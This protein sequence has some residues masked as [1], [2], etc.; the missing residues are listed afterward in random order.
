MSLVVTLSVPKSV[1]GEFRT[2]ANDTNYGLHAAVYTNDL[3]TAIRA[4]R[5]ACRLRSRSTPTGSGESDNGPVLTAG[6]LP[7]VQLGAS[8]RD[9]TMASISATSASVAF[10]PNAELNT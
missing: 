10:G 3:D 5:V 9:L 1:V 8:S 2:V 7:L 6:P 4:A